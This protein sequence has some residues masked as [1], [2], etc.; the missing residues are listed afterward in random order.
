MDDLAAGEQPAGRGQRFAH[1]VGDLVDVLA[2]E[3]RHPRIERAVVADRLGDV[4]VVGAAEQEV[5]LAMAGGDM[6]EPG[7]GVD[8]HEI[9]QQQRGV[10]VVPMTPQWMGADDAFQRLAFVDV[11]DVVRG[12]AGVL[13][14]LGQQRQRDQ[15]RLVVAGQ[16]AG[17]GAIDP[18]QRVVDLRPG[19][20]GAVAG[21]GP[22]RGGPDDHRGAL[23][24]LDRRLED[25]EADPDRGAGVVVVFD[26]RLGQRGL[27]HRRPHHRTEPAIQRAIQQEFQDFVR[28]GAFGWQ[29]HGRVT[30]TPRAF[31]AQSA[32][33]AG[34]DAHPMRGVGAALGAEIQHRDGVLV[35]LFGAILF[36]DL[37]LDRQPVAVPAGDV[38]GVVAGHLTRAVDHILEDFVQRGADVQMPVRVRRAIVQNEH[39]PALRGRAQLAPQIHRLPAGEDPGLL[40]RQ[41]PAHRE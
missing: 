40:L 12:D 25:R 10:L 23:Q 31:D 27:L 38:V 24:F 26:L 1:R 8:G 21:H 9:R 15:H 30:L 20:D 3:Q 41:I 22:G 37:P 36:L 32:E 33:L 7:A 19:G 13:Q 16:R 28:D 4:E 2:G 6:D 14:H 5:V 34:L 29:I 39:R 35:L 11:Q 17:L 18:D